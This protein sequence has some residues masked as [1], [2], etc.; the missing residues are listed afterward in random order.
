[1]S[2]RN[3]PRVDGVSVE[4]TKHADPGEGGKIPLPDNHADVCTGDNCWCTN[5]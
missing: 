2:D 4:P 1:M 3:A 5:Y